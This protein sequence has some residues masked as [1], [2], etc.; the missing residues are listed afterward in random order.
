VD[1]RPAGAEVLETHGSESVAQKVEH[2]GAGQ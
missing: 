1:I 2:F